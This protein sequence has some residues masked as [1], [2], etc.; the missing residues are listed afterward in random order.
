[1]QKNNLSCGAP[2]IVVAKGFVFG[3]KLIEI[4][5]LE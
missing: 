5:I 1:M 4:D 2:A 3:Q